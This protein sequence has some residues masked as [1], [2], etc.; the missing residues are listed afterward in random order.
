MLLHTF[1]QMDQ[2]GAGGQEMFKLLFYKSLGAAPFFYVTGKVKSPK[3]V[4]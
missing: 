4:L 1:I 2:Q 3:L